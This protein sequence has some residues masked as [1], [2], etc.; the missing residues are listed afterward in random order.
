MNM[1]IIV[2]AATALCLGTGATGQGISDQRM[3]AA[4]R[5]LQAMHYDR[6]LDRTVEAII[7]EVEQSIDAKLSKGVAEPLPAEVLTKIKGIA[8]AHMRRVFVEHRAELR[9]GTALIYAKHFTVSE[10]DRL[11]KLQSDPAMAK[12]QQELPQ[13]MAETMG[14][15]Q[16]MASSGEEQLKRDIE[17]VLIDYLRQ[18][19]R[20]PSS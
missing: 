17:S 11:A 14:L 2:L 4:E 3:A 12:M 7:K 20:S 13:I 9:R 1:R 16:A 8:D 5:L 6:Q 15:S 10:L 19:G 18:K